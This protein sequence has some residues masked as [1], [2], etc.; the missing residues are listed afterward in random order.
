MVIIYA[1]ASFYLGSLA[2]GISPF[3]LELVKAL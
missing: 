2:S 1:A 3:H